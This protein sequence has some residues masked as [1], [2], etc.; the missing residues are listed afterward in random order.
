MRR[1]IFFI[2]TIALC[3][4]SCGSMHDTGAP[5]MNRPNITIL[6]SFNPESYPRFIS[7]AY[8][9]MAVWITQPGMKFARTIYATN[10]GSKDSYW[11]AD[12]RPYALPVWYGAREIEARTTVDAV[13]GATPSGESF[14]I[15]WNVPPELRGKAVDVF[16][17]ANVAFDYNAAFP[18]S[19]KSG[20]AGFSE[21]NGQPSLVWKARFLP[22]NDRKE[23]SPVIAGHGHVLGTDH[24][25]HPDI[26]G[27]STAKGIFHYIKVIYDPGK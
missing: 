5:D 17:E 25:I 15:R 26:S 11:G 8:P 3:S 7:K 23:I 4:L 1:M 16:I 10:K 19:A 6:F 27:V 2:A 20:E 22:G 21:V 14:S 13:T 12:T 24:D 18:K 9:Q